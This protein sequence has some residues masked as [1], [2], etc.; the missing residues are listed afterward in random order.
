MQRQVHVGGDDLGGIFNRIGLTAILFLSG[1]NFSCSNVSFLGIKASSLSQSSSSSSGLSISVTGAVLSTT[2]DSVTITPTFKGTVNSVSISPALTNGLTLNTKTGVITGTLTGAPSTT[3][4]T[5]TAT[6]PSVT[7]TATVTLT[8]LATPTVAVPASPY[9]FSL[10]V[11]ISNITPTLSSSV[12]SVAISPS[13]PTGLS[14]DP[15]TGIISGTPTATSPATY[16]TLTVKD[17]AGDTGTN[18]LNSFSILVNQ[19]FG[20]G[21]TG[22]LDVAGLGTTVNSYSAITG[23]TGSPWSTISVSSG[24]F[25]AGQEILV[26]QM[27]GP[28]TPFPW[29]FATVSSFAG[30]VITLS[31]PLQNTYAYNAGAVS[32]VV[33]VPHYTNVTVESGASIVPQAWNG[34]TGGIVV[35]RANGIVT[36]N[37]NISADGTGFVGG[38]VNHAAFAA[39][40]AGSGESWIGASLSQTSN[41]QGGGGGGE[42]PT[43]FNMSG[44]CA[45]SSGSYITALAGAGGYA[46]VGSSFVSSLTCNAVTSIFGT[47]GSTYGSSDLTA[48]LFLGSGGGGDDIWQFTA[49]GGYPG[50]SGGGLV[51]IYGQQITGTATM[52]STISANGQGQSSGAGAGGSGGTVYLISNTLTLDN[53][54]V[55]AAGGAGAKPDGSGSWNGGRNGGDG[56]IRLDYNSTTGAMPSTPAPGYT[57]TPMQ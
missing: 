31:A 46:T 45:S 50:G 41:N 30:G 32:Q 44:G 38:A 13:L 49:N 29:E 53:L 15:V 14:M 23:G 21:S 51:L 39:T 33:T 3:V 35:F 6:G 25:T 42:D 16:Y 57:L 10:G 43:A 1:A 4:Y 20:D 19:A 37:G 55:S 52:T 24:S 12:T 18:A 11:P 26:I 48:G 36:V 40:T 2:G 54:T 9:T 5:L 7:A 28:S 56:R 17:A 22:P 34:T 8:I 27:Q 47:G